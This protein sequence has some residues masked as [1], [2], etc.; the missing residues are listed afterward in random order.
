M[1]RLPGISQKQAVR[2]FQKLGYRVVRES[3][4]LIM[5]NGTSRLVIPRH[6][7]I[8]AITMGAIAR[9]A[10]LTL[11]SSASCSD[12]PWIHREGV[13]WHQSSA[14]DLLFI[15]LRKSEA[16][17]SP[18]TR[19][20]DLALGPAL[21]HWKSQSSTTATSPTGQRTIHHASRGSK[22][23]LYRFAEACSYV[24]E[25]RKQDGRPGAPTEPFMCLG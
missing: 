21:L 14:T 9:D 7:P 1:P 23:L 12:G 16:L 24:R 3:G 10:G 18:S 17:F 4:H 19:Y 6:D 15:T 13:L 25:Q 8:N 5:S 22:V 20:R 2:V 11:S